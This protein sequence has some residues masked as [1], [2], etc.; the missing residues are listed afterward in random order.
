M[1]CPTQLCLFEKVAIYCSHNWTSHFFNK[2]RC[3]GRTTWRFVTECSIAQQQELYPIT[4]CFKL[5]TNTLRWR[6][7]MVNFSA[8][9]FSLA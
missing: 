4:D 3:A 8:H 9:Y 6:C 2:H 7:C 1:V 5:F